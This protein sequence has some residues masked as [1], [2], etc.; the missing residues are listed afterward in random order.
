M[1]T[2]QSGQAKTKGYRPAGHE[3]FNE[4]SSA[5]NGLYDGSVDEAEEVFGE[6]LVQKN[7]DGTTLEVSRT[8]TYIIKITKEK[9]NP[10]I[11]KSFNCTV[12]IN[13]WPGDML[14]RSRQ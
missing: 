1:L 9:S 11:L 8:S 4:L 5:S 10:F 14:P 7:Q 2:S 6:V 12:T 3:L 13:K